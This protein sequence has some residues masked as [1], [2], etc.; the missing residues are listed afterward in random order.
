MTAFGTFQN[1]KRQP[2]HLLLQITENS[3]CHYNCV[4]MCETMCPSRK[5]HVICC[6]TRRI[7]EIS[8]FIGGIGFCSYIFMA[9]QTERV[10][11]GKRAKN[12]KSN[13]SFY[14][15][16]QKKDTHIAQCTKCGVRWIICSLFVCLAWWAVVFLEVNSPKLNQQTG[17]N[18]LPFLFITFNICR[19]ACSAFP[20]NPI[21]NYF[22]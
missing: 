8:V 19:R 17:G 2:T 12:G 13:N 1:K 20:F 6:H 4:D 18:I 21:H 3:I 9:M 15:R 16:L 5:N 14:R 10:R 11:E 22:I 7:Y